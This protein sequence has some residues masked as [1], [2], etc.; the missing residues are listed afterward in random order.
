MLRF[1]FFLF[2]QI[3]LPCCLYA[4]MI[5]LQI[6]VNGVPRGEFFV[7]RE[8]SGNF[9]LP[10]ADLSNLGLLI[11]PQEIWVVDDVS[12]FSLKEFPEISLSLEE[13]SL[14]LSIVSPPQYL[15]QSVIDLSWR[16]TEKVQRP[17]EASTF[18]NYRLSYDTDSRS[19][20]STSGLASEVGL[21]RE[22]F[23][24]LSGQRYETSSE[25]T[26]FIRQM[27]TVTW[28]NR[29]ELRRFIVGDAVTP[30]TLLAPSLYLGG[31]T[32]SR[33]FDLDPS[34]IRY[35]TFDYT[36]SIES[37]GE[38]DVYQNG[39]KIRTEKLPPG[40][41]HLENLSGIPG[42]GD[43]EVVLRDQFGRETKL[44]TPFYLSEQLLKPG[45]Q[46]YSY[47]AGLLRDGYASID[48]SY[49]SAI[50][51]GV[52]RYGWSRNLTVGYTLQAGDGLVMVAP[53]MDIRARTAGVF[54]L[55]AGANAGSQG[56]GAALLRYAYSHRP[57]SGS[58]EYHFFSEGWRTLS[59]TTMN[60]SLPQQRLRG[61]LSWGSLSTGSL[62]LDAEQR[63]FYDSS[64]QTSLGAMYS[65]RIFSHVNLNLFL[66][67]TRNIVN[68]G[69]IFAVFTYSPGEKLQASLRLDLQRDK[70][71]QELDIQKNTPSGAGYGYVATAGHRSDDA[72]GATYLDLSREQHSRYMNLWGRGYFESG[73]TGTETAFSLAA[74]GA[75]TWVGGHFEPSRP[76]DDSFALVRVGALPDV[77]VYRNGEEVGRTNAHGLLLVPGLSSY[78]DNRISL[79]DTDI[80]IEYQ[81]KKV[82]YYISPPAR[83][84][85]CVDFG[86][87]SSQ[88]VTGRFSF[89]QKGRVTPLEYREVVLVN[90]LEEK[91][92]IPTGQGGE[93]YFDPQ[94]FT[95]LQEAEREVKGCEALLDLAG[96]KTVLPR[97]RATVWLADKEQTFNLEVP[98][99]E[100]LFVDLGEIVIDVE[101]GQ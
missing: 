7:E 52:H 17:H 76:V 3:L 64:S 69:S 20:G 35:P 26:R 42:Y 92:T 45:L 41:F 86:V 77:T 57:F 11:K 30:A 9:L 21:R 49:S 40:P 2:S 58:L 74:A 99:S 80:P 96:E 47:S 79:A 25:K 88:P 24:I 38:I 61:A 72:G 22:D 27:T 23:L 73:G 43:I 1:F 51:L 50:L 44:S 33:N 78:Y 98:A 34:F 56:G 84:G 100:D 5:V 89:R 13:S 65:R 60:S 55:S 75:F 36:G 12:Y 68:E 6:D 18:V 46:E 37:P 59:G 87:V 10:I 16:Q 97:Y 71:S 39:Y 90:S 54:S 95:S 91:L 19:N 14:T 101:T 94:D 15:P 28:E 4:E 63:S 82:D 85:S 66:R 8:A 93:F 81:L 83:S 62:S 31:V 48:D 70:S 67:Q 29:D 53:Q 32:I